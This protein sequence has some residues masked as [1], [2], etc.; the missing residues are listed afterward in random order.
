MLFW[1]VN[2]Y[3]IQSKDEQWF[4]SAFVVFHSQSFTTILLLKVNF[5]EIEDKDGL[6]FNSYFIQKI[7][8]TYY[9]SKF[10]LEHCKTWIS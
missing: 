10:K 6:W 2:H 1:K 9:T 8:N 7:N 5:Y 3:E 4:L